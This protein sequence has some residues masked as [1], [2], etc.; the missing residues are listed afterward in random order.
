M[1][2]RILPYGDRALLVE[3]ESLDEVLALHRALVQTAPPGVVD[4]VPA[5]RT[6]AV[7]VDPAR[8]PLGTARAWAAGV[9]APVRAADAAADAA[10][11]TADATDAVTIDV[12]YSG[13]DLAEVARLL[14][15][16]VDEVVALHTGS[17]WRVAFGG[18]APGFGY[19]VTDHDRLRVP[20]RSNPRT[21]VPSGSVG[22]AGEFSG[23]YPLQSPGGWQLI[24]VTDA[25][26]WDPE[27]EQPALL[28]PGRTVRFVRRT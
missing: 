13:E 5:A 27:R 17:V 8:L 19:L 28:T 22:L 23:V 1:T 14:G 12:D 9:P 10:P 25:P 24:G 20:R 2:R 16:G 7:T 18:F 3:V 15:L 26:L 21:A 6:V 11:K 4:I